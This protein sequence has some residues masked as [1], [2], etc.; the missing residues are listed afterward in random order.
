VYNFA[1]SGYICPIC[2]TLD[3]KETKD[4]LI[5]QKDIVYKDKLVTAF[6]ASFFIGKNPGHVIVVPNE[7]FENIFDLPS[8]F[9]LR[10]HQVSKRVSVALKQ[11]YKA[12]GITLLQNNGPEG[13]QHAFHYHLH[14]FPRHKGDRLHKFM[15][16][17]KQSDTKTR[18]KYANILKPLL[19]TVK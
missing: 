11:G 12:E 9:A 13:G 3:G 7:H 16:S 1:P 8:K 10:I 2:V 6:I 14:V 17:K 5:K 18:A 19:K 4:T 15:D